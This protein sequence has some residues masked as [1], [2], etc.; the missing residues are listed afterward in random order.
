M[1]RFRG[2]VD[3][4]IG[5]ELVPSEDAL[6]AA[7]GV[8]PGTELLDDP[9]CKADRRIIEAITERLRRGRLKMAVAPLGVP[10]GAELIEVG[11]GSLIVLRLVQRA[12]EKKPA[13]DIVEVNADEALCVIEAKGDRNGRAPI[14]ALGG[15][16][17]VAEPVHQTRPECCNLAWIRAWFAR[18]VGEPVAR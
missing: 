5:E 8:A 6:E 11:I 13:G 3:H 14:T 12:A 2:P 15:E 9:G 18:T 4:H 1:D 16:A 17:P 10:P 7:P